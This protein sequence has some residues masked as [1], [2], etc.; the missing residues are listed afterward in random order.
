MQINGLEFVEETAIPF[1]FTFFLFSSETSLV[2]KRRM[3]RFFDDLNSSKYLPNLFSCKNT[4]PC[5]WP[6]LAL[7][8]LAKEQ[9]KN[10]FESDLLW[11]AE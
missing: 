8:H 9:H 10:L 5:G 4:N 6:L 2:Y 3:L 7:G 11:Y 1:Q